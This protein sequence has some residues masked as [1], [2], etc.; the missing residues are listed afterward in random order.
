[1]SLE[2][3][4]TEV[5]RVSQLT[6]SQVNDLARTVAGIEQHLK[7]FFDNPENEKAYQDWYFRKYGRMDK[8]SNYD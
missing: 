4:N 2:K 7:G 8:E 6:S 5:D 3:P 1:M